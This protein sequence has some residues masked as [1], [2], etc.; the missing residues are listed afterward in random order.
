[1]QFN[2]AW[3]RR[4]LRALDSQDGGARA[5]EIQ[6]ILR[7]AYITQVRAKRALGRSFRDPKRPIRCDIAPERLYFRCTV[8]R[9][10]PRDAATLCFGSPIGAFGGRR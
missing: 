10:P 4:F 5:A 2:A 1:M 9:S 8:D 3:V 6:R 7:T